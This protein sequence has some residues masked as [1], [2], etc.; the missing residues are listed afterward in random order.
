MANPNING[1]PGML[2]I[3]T[4]DDQ[5]TEMQYKTKRHDQENILKSSERDNEYFRK[6]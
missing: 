3:K 4:K 2:K 6:L 1:D 5:L